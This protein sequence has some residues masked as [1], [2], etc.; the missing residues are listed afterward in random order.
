MA[1]SITECL[2]AVR[3]MYT[4]N[5]EAEGGEVVVRCQTEESAKV[6]EVSLPVLCIAAKK[7]SKPRYATIKGV[8]NSLRVEI[9]EITLASLSDPDTTK[10]G[11]KGSL[12]K[13]KAIFTSK[14][15]ASCM[16]IEGNSLA[17]AAE[18]LTDRLAGVRTL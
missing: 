6:A 3:P 17:E 8:L 15:D 13:I 5:T 16:S 2:E 10:M 11:L 18:T 1:P 12:T 4:P 7:G 9:G 14:R